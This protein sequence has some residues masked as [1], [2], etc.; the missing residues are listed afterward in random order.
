VQSSE[1]GRDSSASATA[2]IH[3]AKDHP[4]AETHSVAE[5]AAET[6]SEAAAPPPTHS[7]AE[8]PAA[9][10]S[11]AEATHET[12]SAPEASPE[13]ASSTA[14]THSA[15]ETHSAPEATAEAVAETDAGVAAASGTELAPAFQERIRASSSRSA[16]EKNRD[17]HLTGKTPPQTSGQSWTLNTEA[18]PFGKSSGGADFTGKGTVKNP[19][20]DQLNMAKQMNA[21]G[22]PGV[23]T[24]SLS[25]SA[26]E[27]QTV[28]KAMYQL[29]RLIKRMP[30]DKLETRKETPSPTPPP[31]AFARRFEPFGK[32]TSSI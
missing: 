31:Y 32:G 28:L 27:L 9:A 17:V 7:A 22:E 20:A 3:S 6:H 21:F 13:T 14:E 1:T 30:D 8:A 5:A 18:L 10:H 12:H 19:V 25:S 11:E 4:A 23:T 15:T 29:G 16:A 2:E 24:T 26:T